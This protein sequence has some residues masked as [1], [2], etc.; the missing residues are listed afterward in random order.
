VSGQ[1]FV[2]FCAAAR[3]GAFGRKLE[4]AKVSDSGLIGRVKVQGGK[5]RAW[6]GRT[7]RQRSGRRPLRYHK[8]RE[9]EHKIGSV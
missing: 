4:G 1:V 9:D 5:I 3:G 7:G 6:E 8:E 2:V